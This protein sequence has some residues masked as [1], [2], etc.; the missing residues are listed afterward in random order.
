MIKRALLV[1]ALSQ[2]AY[3]MAKLLHEKGYMLYGII[4]K[5]TRDDRLVELKKLY[6]SMIFY[7]KD[8]TNQQDLMDV[9][10]TVQPDEMYN[11][12]G[13]SDVIDPYANLGQIMAVNSA[14]VT[15][16]LVTLALNSRHTK[17]F[18][19]SSRLVFGSNYGHLNELSAKSP[20]IPYGAAKL[21]ADEEIDK[22]RK[23]GIFACSGIFFNHE[24]E[25]RPERFFSR[26]VSMG[27]AKLVLGLS[28][29]IK[30]GNLTSERDF[31]Y[32]GDFVEAAWMMLQSP[33]PMDYVIGTG[34]I[35]S[36]GDYLN[37]AISMYDI[38][39]QARIIH[40]TEPHRIE[41]HAQRANINR[42][43]DELGWFPKTSVPEIIKKMVDHDIALLKKQIA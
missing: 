31:G 23:R 33:K 11:F 28:D 30:M 15:L 2:D 39:T 25:R 6:P 24:S 35:M 17:F 29:E 13:V 14:A 34:E 32:A 41:E 40:N 8:I 1:G 22:W 16:M 26:K 9:I 10:I 7:K 37:L 3:F 20:L 5:D 36:T 21:S 27:V 43:K 42:I 19:A 38:Q 12:A 4:K 18:Q